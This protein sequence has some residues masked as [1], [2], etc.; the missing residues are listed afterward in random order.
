MLTSFHAAS[1]LAALRAEAEGEALRS[2]GIFAS[3]AVEH[4]LDPLGIADS[5]LLGLAILW[6][7]RHTPWKPKSLPPPL[8]VA[9]KA[10]GRESLRQVDTIGTLTL[11]SPPSHG[12]M[13][14]CC[15][16]SCP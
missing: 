12:P 16:C 8:P 9:V 1:T 4:W 10:C 11:P 15:L 14:P 6:L 3:G 5:F 2:Q 13:P 7:V